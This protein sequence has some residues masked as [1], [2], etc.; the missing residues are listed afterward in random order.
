MENDI[1]RAKKLL[2]GKGYTIEKKLFDIDESDVVSLNEFID[3]NGDDYGWEE[4]LEESLYEY[5]EDDRL[6]ESSDQDKVY[7]PGDII[8]TRNYYSPSSHKKMKENPHKILLVTS[9]QES[10]GVV[11]YRGFLLSSKV[12]K[13]NKEGKYPNNIYIDNYS[14]I[15]SSGANSNKEAIIRVDDLVQF[16][17]KDL[18]HSGT[19]KGE[20]SK[21]FI[22][23]VK[24]CYENY[25]SGNSKY[26]FNQQWLSKSKEVH[27]G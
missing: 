26:N 13:A 24:K 9:K 14:S 17:N 25:R 3:M 23:F 18:S 21:E 27:N 7:E 22:E 12:N 6:Y 2:E 8:M 4:S 15:L 19:K 10:N 20:A 11:Y 16:T 1:R 5:E